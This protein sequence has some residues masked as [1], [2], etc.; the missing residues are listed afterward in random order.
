MLLVRFGVPATAGILPV[1]LRAEP[2]APEK[3]G[4]A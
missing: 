2:A 1:K 4:T 3:L